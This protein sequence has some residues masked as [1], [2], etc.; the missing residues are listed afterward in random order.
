MAPITL[1]EAL[2][3]LK[4]LKKCHEELTALRNDKP[5]SRRAV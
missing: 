3:W 4:T 5:R 2:V 1:N